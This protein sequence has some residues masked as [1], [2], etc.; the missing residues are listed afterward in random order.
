[1]TISTGDRLPEAVFL[2]IGADGGP[3]ELA[4]AA[5]FA[6]RRVVL[7]ALP[8]AFTRTCSAAHLPSFL[9][10]APEFHAK[11]VDEIICLAVNDPFVMKA[12][13]EANDVA[14]AGIRIDYQPWLV[15]IDFDL[16]VFLSDKPKLFFAS[17]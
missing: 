5:V 3:A 17:F 9:R 13:G 14:A 4:S 6:G 7:F 2:E 16:P 1:M 12:W 10:T 8:G 11:G 15:R